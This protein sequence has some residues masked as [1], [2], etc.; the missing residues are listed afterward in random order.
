[1]GPVVAVVLSEGEV[2]S[3][4]DLSSGNDSSAFGNA[5]GNNYGRLAG[6]DFE[7]LSFGV[8]FSPEINSVPLGSS[9]EV[10]S[11]AVASSSNA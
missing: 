1:V 10:V 3:S 11:G 9:G 6:V 5:C 8:S 7:V 2:G 4:V